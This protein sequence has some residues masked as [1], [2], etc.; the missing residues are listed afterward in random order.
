MGE[1]GDG[2]EKGRPATKPFSK[3]CAVYPKTG[4]GSDWITHKTP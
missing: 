3:S 4:C 2:K 1:E